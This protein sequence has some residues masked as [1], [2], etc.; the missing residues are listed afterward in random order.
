MKT[1]DKFNLVTDEMAELYAR[2]NKDYGNSFDRSLDE[3]GLL[4]TKIRLSDKINRFSTLIKNDALV[5]DESI[6][7]TL[8]DLANYAVM[9]IMW[10]DAGN[11]KIYDDKTSGETGSWN[12]TL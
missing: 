3:D 7:D 5:K 9:T 1:T 6:R 4:V 10:L 12:G 2:K 11:A 8:I